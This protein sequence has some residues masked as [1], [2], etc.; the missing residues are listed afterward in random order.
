MHCLEVELPP[1]CPVT[2]DFVECDRNESVIKY[3]VPKFAH[4][5]FCLIVFLLSLGAVERVALYQVNSWLQN[6]HVNHV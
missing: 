1:I 6:N 4:E 5:L 3:D 2:M